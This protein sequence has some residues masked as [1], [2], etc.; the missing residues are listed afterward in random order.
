MKYC[1]NCGT[2][3]ELRIPEGDTLP[4]YVCSACNVIHYQNPKIVVGCIPEWEDRILLCRRAIEPRL[5]LWTMPSGFMENAE[6]LVQGAE[7]ETLEEANARVEMGDLYSIYNVPHINQV[8]VL[9]RAR[10]LDMDFKPGIESLDVKL[11][12]E[13]EIP[14]DALAFRVIREP[15]KRYF[16]ERRQGKLSFHMGTIEE[17]RE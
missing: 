14:W 5:G 15:L 7:R 12:H 2:A 17:V 8:H 11:F 4:R 1:S 10:L 9:F 6:T 13:A 16:E 3:V